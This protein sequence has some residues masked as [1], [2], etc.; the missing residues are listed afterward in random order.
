MR[1]CAFLYTALSHHRLFAHQPF[2]QNTLA[3]TNAL[4][5]ASFSPS[6]IPQKSYCPISL[7][8][9]P[10]LSLSNTSAETKSIHEYDLPQLH[11]YLSQNQIAQIFQ[12][13][14]P[15][16]VLL[17][18]QQGFSSYTLDIIPNDTSLHKQHGLCS[19]TS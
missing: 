4:P 8:L 5:K 13:I 6:G 3:P 12:K 2:S 10:Q 14:A 11:I 17:S 15:L 18:P 19:S 16:P 9:S 1:N 7:L